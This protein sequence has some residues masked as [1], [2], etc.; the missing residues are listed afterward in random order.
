MQ[1]ALIVWG[2]VLIRSLVVKAGF[3]V[4]LVVVPVKVVVAVLFFG[5]ERFYVYIK[6]NFVKKVKLPSHPAGYIDLTAQKN[7]L[8]FYTGMAK[9]ATANLKKIWK[10]ASHENE[11]VYHTDDFFSRFG[12][13][14][15]SEFTFADLVAVISAASIDPAQIR[16]READDYYTSW[17]EIVVTDMNF[18]KAE[19][20]RKFNE[21]QDKHTKDLSN[22]NQEIINLQTKI[23]EI[24]QHNAAATLSA[25]CTNQQGFLGTHGVKATVIP[26][27]QNKMLVILS[28]PAEELN[29]LDFGYPVEAM[30]K[31]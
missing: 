8:I 26:W 20:L 11:I 2:L 7:G 14:I 27:E 31:V 16:I 1:S 25:C 12:L 3:A 28:A 13:T 4:Q 5:P 10:L 29:L 22:A 17:Y 9:N 19:S 23:D 30:V 6:L 18:I 21:E 24:E 15:E